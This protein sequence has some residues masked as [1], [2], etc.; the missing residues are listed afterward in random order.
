[1]VTSPLKGDLTF[2]F[3]WTTL[4]T[5]FFLTVV[6]DLFSQSIHFRNLES[7][8]AP[9][10]CTETYLKTTFQFLDQGNVLLKDPGAILLKYNP[11]GRLHPYF[12]VSVGGQGSN[13]NGCLAP[14]YKLQHAS[15][16]FLWVRA[17]TTHRSPKYL[18]TAA[19][20]NSPA[21]CFS[22]VE[23]DLP[24]VVVL[25]KVFLACFTL[26]WCSFSLMI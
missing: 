25:N 26:P 19:L 21:A 14:N 10:K 22:R 5:S 7:F 18:P 23:F 24:V 15:L 20:K 1:M 13:F 11:Q 4:R 12:L 8:S 6:P 2:P 9:L 16:L 17:I 3:P